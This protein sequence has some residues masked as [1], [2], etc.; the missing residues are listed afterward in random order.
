MGWI[1]AR[2]RNHPHGDIIS[3][4]PDTPDLMQTL[5]RDFIIHG[6]TTEILGY[7]D[8][9]PDDTWEE[10]WN[11]VVAKQKARDKQYD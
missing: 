4:I 10:S 11:R 8:G 3:R 9:I 1:I 7:V 2:Q 5:I 6:R